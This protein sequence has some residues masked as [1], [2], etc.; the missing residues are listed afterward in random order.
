MTGNEL[1][2]DTVKNFCRCWFEERDLAGA[3]SY[4][5]EDI[6]F[7]GT[8]KAEDANGKTAMLDYLRRDIAEIREPFQVI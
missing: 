8:G 1:I 2:W 6:T 3:A 7:V 4:L 5:A